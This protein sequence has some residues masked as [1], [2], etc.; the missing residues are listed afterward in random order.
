MYDFT[1][2]LSGHGETK[3]QTVVSIFEAIKRLPYRIDTPQYLSGDALIGRSRSI[4]ASRFL[5]ANDS[6]YMIII[7]TDIM[8]TPDELERLYKA[9]VGGCDVI[10]GAYS[11]ASGDHLAI[12]GYGE[13]VQIDGN[14]HEI[15]YVSTGFMGIS[16]K[17][18]ETIRAKCPY[19]KLDYTKATCIWEIGLPHLHKGEWCECYPFFE[20]GSGN[21]V[22]AAHDFYLSEDWNF[23]LEPTTPVL[24][25]DFTWKALGAVNIGDSIIGFDAPESNYRRYHH[26]QVLDRI[27]QTTETYRVITDAGELIGSGNH[28]MLASSPSTKAPRWIT[29]SRLKPMQHLTMPVTPYANPLFDRQYM[30]GYIK[31]LWEGD[32]TI[33]AK[34][35][36]ATLEMA[37]RE[38]VDR[39]HSFLSAMDYR[40]GDI[41]SRKLNNPNWR[42]LWGFRCT[43]GI[44]DI[45]GQ[46]LQS[47]SMCKGF[48]A[49]IYDAEGSHSAGHLRIAM[50]SEQIRFEIHTA[51]A[52]LGLNLNMR[53]RP[54]G[55]FEFWSSKQS[56]CHRFWQVVHPAI[57][58]K[59]SIKGESGNA[60]MQ[61]THPTILAVERQGKAGELQCLTTTSASFIAGGFA[62]HNCDK[63]RWSGLK[64]YLHSGCMVDHVKSG[65]IAAESVLQKH[66]IQSPGQLNPDVNLWQDIAEWLNKPPKEVNEKIVNYQIV[67]KTPDDENWVYELA[68]YNCFEN[69]K[70]Q[71]LA[72]LAGV[73]GSRV[74]D[75][76]CGIGTAAML[77]GNAN[78]V[79]GYDINPRCIDL[80]NYRRTK[81]G[82]QNVDFTT[83]LPDLKEFQVVSLINVLECV[84]DPLP[85]LKEIAGGLQKGAKV[86]HFED[87]PPPNKEIPGRYN[88]SAKLSNCFVEAGFIEFNPVWAIKT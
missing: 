55:L 54:D 74:L 87:Y 76:G 19:P 40:V 21:I 83:K 50:R 61:S 78:I 2:W 9:M 1:I 36:Y 86:F 75:Y 41:R 31:G 84:P 62:S 32:G 63:A 20:S 25:S 65:V 53:S 49:G 3:D 39:A 71:R 48:L 52:R 4:A 88:H 7:D 73:T 82:M 12:R 37:D 28:P 80:A 43:S 14:V 44:T 10:G 24:M 34:H 29:I 38:A 8:F 22:G 26:A 46:E 42:D 13:S 51:L 77:M 15:E 57:S 68:K 16:R 67:A 17:A 6:P 70:T 30:L 11:V 59:I 81:H 45:V 27:I 58:R 33:E 66:K 5:A 85:V 72:P 35:G 64:V 60:I 23:P 47:L 56:E 79:T 69:Y 18:L